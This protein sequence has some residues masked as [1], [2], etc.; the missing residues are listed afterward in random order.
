MSPRGYHCRFFVIRVVVVVGASLAM[1]PWSHLALAYAPPQL[2]PCGFHGR[3]LTLAGSGGGGWSGRAYM[4]NQ[5][6]EY[7]TKEGVNGGG[8]VS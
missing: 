6:I 3:G 2:R 8:P 5:P 7:K 4:T 1:L